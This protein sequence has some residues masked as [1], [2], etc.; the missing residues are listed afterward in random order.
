MVDGFGEE[1]VERCWYRERARKRALAVEVRDGQQAQV[2]EL[3][4]G[5]GMG[6]VQDEEMALR[7]V[8][9]RAGSKWLM[10]IRFP[11]CAS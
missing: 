8:R 1:I 10:A 3:L 7:R 6:L 11:D 4:V 9:P 5:Q 2:L